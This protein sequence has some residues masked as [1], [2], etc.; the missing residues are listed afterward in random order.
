MRWV[1][2]A[3]L[4][5]AACGG[6]SEEGAT[7]TERREPSTTTTESPESPLGLIE[8]AYQG[9]G[10]RV[11]VLGDSLTVQS[12]EALGRELAAYALKVGAFQGEGLAGG[13]FSEGF[14]G[15]MMLTTARTYARDDPDV[16]VIALGTND[17]W[18]PDIELPAALDAWRT[19]AGHFESACIVGVTVTET[20]T[21]A[22]YD[23]DEAR[24][25]ND[26]IVAGSDQVVEWRELA[27]RATDGEG[28]HLTPEG[29]E[30]RAAAIRRAV[31]ACSPAEG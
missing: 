18:S 5:L 11:V 15:T 26:L 29:A 9:D 28:I 10:P 14:G 31:D 8:E 24:A 23:A 27:A 21:A 7:T 2:A 13:P 17:A 16:A 6:G 4:V 20:A 22:G 1:A 19:I 12:R 25:I 30:L 3:L